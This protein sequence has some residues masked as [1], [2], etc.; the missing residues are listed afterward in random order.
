MCKRICLAGMISIILSLGIFLISCD[1][2]VRTPDNNFNP[3]DFAGSWGGNIMGN[4]VSVVIIGSGWTITVPGL[5]MDVGT[6]TVM[7]DGMTAVLHSTNFGR[8]VG[9]AVVFDTNTLRLMLNENSFS[10]GTHILTRR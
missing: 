1:N 7:E 2:N 5:G 4:N 10:P 8:I 3:A 9:V 6:Y